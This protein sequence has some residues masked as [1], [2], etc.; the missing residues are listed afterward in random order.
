M[1]ILLSDMESGRLSMLRFRALSGEHPVL[2]DP[3]EQSFSENMIDI[4]ISIMDTRLRVRE[5]YMDLMEVGRC[6]CIIGDRFRLV[7]KYR[8]SWMSFA[9]MMHYCCRC[10]RRSTA[11]VPVWLTDQL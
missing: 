1:F 5:G 11:V 6:R 4:M 8:L 2:V 7:R 3:R 10:R 9:L